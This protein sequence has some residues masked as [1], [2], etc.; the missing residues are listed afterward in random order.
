[1]AIKTYSDRGSIKDIHSK[2]E[3]NSPADDF[4]LNIKNGYEYAL[5]TKDDALIQSLGLVAIDGSAKD[6]IFLLKHREYVNKLIEKNAIGIEETRK[7]LETCFNMKPTSIEVRD[8]FFKRINALN[9]ILDHKTDHFVKT[10]SQLK[11]S[12]SRKVS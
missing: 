9:S 4:E 2:D 5:A 1:M 11:R 8:N 10:A 3:D 7:E 6:P 12:F